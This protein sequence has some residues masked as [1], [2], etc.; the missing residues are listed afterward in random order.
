MTQEK[1]DRTARFMVG[2]A[3]HICNEFGRYTVMRRYWHPVI[4]LAYDLQ[5]SLVSRSGIAEKVVEPFDTAR[6]I[7][8]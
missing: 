5:G 2:E 3:V 1:V 7:G 8:P 6:T 4:G